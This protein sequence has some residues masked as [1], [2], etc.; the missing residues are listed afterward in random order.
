VHE[1]RVYPKD[2]TG[3]RDA[4]TVSLHHFTVQDD[5]RELYAVSFTGVLFQL[6]QD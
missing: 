3:Q 4:N 1:R 5:L 2:V 6:D